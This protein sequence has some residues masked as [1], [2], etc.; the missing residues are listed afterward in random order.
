MVLYELKTS[1]LNQPWVDHD[2]LIRKLIRGEVFTWLPLL[3]SNVYLLFYIVQQSGK[4]RSLLFYYETIGLS[5]PFK[6][7]NI[8]SLTVNNMCLLKQINVTVNYVLCQPK[9]M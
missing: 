7:Q 1:E 5:F 8:D 6:L 9:Q 3:F 2:D 4:Y